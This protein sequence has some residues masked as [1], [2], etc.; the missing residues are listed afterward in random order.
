MARTHQQAAV[1]PYR[2]RNRQLEVALVTTSSGTRWIVP[3]GSVEVGERARDAA[4]REAEEEGGLRGVIARK[5]LG[6]YRYVKGDAPCR[7][8]VYLMRVTDVLDHWLED[9]FRRRRWLR[10]SDAVACVRE[11]LRPLVHAA[12]LVVEA[13]H[14]SA[15]DRSGGD[16]MRWHRGLWRDVT[17]SGTPGGRR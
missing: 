1:I 17:R 4:R 6:R 9:S 13:R 15:L 7:V 16:E 10:I 3:K 12:Q 5:R 11:E 2:I 14:R 8:D